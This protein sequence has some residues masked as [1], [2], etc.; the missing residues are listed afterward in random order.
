M[1]NEGMDALEGAFD[2]QGRIW[3]GIT[4]DSFEKI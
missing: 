2:R 4:K 1:T 3:N